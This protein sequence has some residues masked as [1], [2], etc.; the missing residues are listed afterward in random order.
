VDPISLVIL[1]AALVAA[2]G[3]VILVIRTFTGGDANAGLR[4]EMRSN[5]RDSR[6]EHQH[7]SR[8]LRDEVGGQLTAT[9]KQLTDSIGAFG[10]THHERL[11]SVLGQM[12]RLTK[13]N[14]ES[15]DQLREGFQQSV[16]RLQ[17]GNEK[18]LDQM[19]QV[20]DEK[21]QT[22]LEKRLGESFKLVSEQLAAVHDGLGE[23]RKLA[24][25]VDDLSRVLNN[26]KTRG[27]FG[28]VQ[29]GALLEQ[30]MAPAQFDRN[31]ETRPGSNRRVEYAVR[32]PGADERQAQV[33]LPIDSKFPLE[34]Y[35]RLV[36]AEEK[37]DFDRVQQLRKLL[38][39]S[40]RNSAKEINE[41]YIEAP[42]T[43]PFGILFLPT[44]SLY[45]EVLRQPG[46]VEDLQDK[47]HILVTGPMTLSALLNSLH[48]GFRTLAIQQRSSE[49][50]LVLSAVKTEFA[51]FGGVLDKVKKQLGAATNTLEQSA[52]RTRA[53]ERKLR[54]VEQLS[55]GEAL[56]VLG[57]PEQSDP[58]D[59]D[60][61]AEDEPDPS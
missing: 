46:L 55:D 49:V 20:V 40:V 21:L 15:I 41:K 42:H 10:Q 52:V 19:R 43:T 51:K 27:T 58:E 13:S 44:E 37:A 28:E 6:E 33:W 2:A 16:A 3:V 4:E 38:E 26:V 22:T 25:G 29:L 48:V 11:E 56:E 59:E 60:E 5:F 9:A 39:R 53:M 36:E 61:P 24:S 34:D 30:I 57:L 45:A 17:E 35:L 14:R 1:A 8:E 50:W 18:K 54:D 31:V 47:E 12:E 7:A 32:L 23:M